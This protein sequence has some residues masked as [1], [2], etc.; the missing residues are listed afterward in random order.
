MKTKM[1]E[2]DNLTVKIDFE[3]CES[4][5]KVQR[6]DEQNRLMYRYD[7]NIESMRERVRIKQEKVDIIEDI[8]SK[9]LAL[10]E[11]KL[12]DHD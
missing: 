2:S 11:R 6:F 5:E 9:S 12:T 7:Q 8:I 3:I 4:A 10:I 1:K